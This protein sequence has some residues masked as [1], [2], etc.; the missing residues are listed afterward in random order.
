MHISIIETSEPAILGTIR[1]LVFSQVVGQMQQAE[2]IVPI[3]DVDGWWTL[4]EEGEEWM[5]QIDYVSQL[6]FDGDEE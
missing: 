2:E 4:T 5:H 6:L 1:S 3:E